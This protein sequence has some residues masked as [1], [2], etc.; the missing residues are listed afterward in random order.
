MP[1]IN[2]PDTPTIGQIFTSGT[3]SWSWD[4]TSWNLNTLTVTGPTGPQGEIG[5]TGPQGVTG[6]QGTSINLIGTVPTVND[7]PASANENDAYIVEADG[8]LYIW[9]TITLVWDNV[10]QIVGPAGPIGP[11]GPTGP[12]GPVGDAGT[13]GAEGAPGA[14]GPT[15]PAGPIG[16]T[17]ADGID[18]AIGPT[19]PQGEQGL[20][21][22]TGP[23]PFNYLGTYDNFYTYT[24]GDAVTYEGSLWK[25]H[26]YIGA[27]GY[28]PTTTNWSLL[29]EV[30]A[31]G[32][33]GS[34]GD[35]GPTG[36]TGPQGADGYI[37]ADGATGPTGP[38]GPEGSFISSATAPLT[39]S[40]GDGWFN[41]ELARMFI[42]YDGYWVEVSSNEAGIAGADGATG[43][44]GPTGPSPSNVS[45]T[46]PTN[47]VDGDI[48]FD[49]VNGGLYTYY[50]SY[51]IELSGA[52]GPTGP[53]GPAGID[54][55]MGQDGATGPTGPAGVVDNY[56]HPYFF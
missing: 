18:G 16:P 52:Q 47:A 42:Y 8:D 53:T 45:S 22:P 44:T 55:I 4:G 5:P 56:V 19:G 40:E 9:D 35:L 23:M 2:F 32:P 37:G 17:G 25:M 21:G 14:T 20:I 12:Q 48:W 27:A 31:T 49:T 28:P 51:W 41:T 33:T 38:T 43:P 50:D 7:L 3:R 36:P 54:G 6:P 26:T 34:Q 13:N 46:P 15:G 11:T 10:G 29:V 39:P 24:V 30:G 1:V